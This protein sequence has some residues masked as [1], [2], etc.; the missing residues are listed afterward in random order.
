[1]GKSVGVGAKLQS[2][3]GLKKLDC[4]LDGLSTKMATVYIYVSKMEMAQLKYTGHAHYL[5]AIASVQEKV[6]NLDDQFVSGWDI[7]L[8]RYRS[9]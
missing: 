9:G 5:D 4:L 8:V 6:A 7:Y 1:M 3:E 2:R